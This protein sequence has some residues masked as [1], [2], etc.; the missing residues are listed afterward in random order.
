[1]IKIKPLKDRAILSEIVKHIQSVLP[2]AKIYLFGSRAKGTNKPRS[3]FDIAI[4]WDKKIPAKILF[5]IHDV[6]GFPR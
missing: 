1:M 2:E 5:Q 6:F 4:Q 3:D